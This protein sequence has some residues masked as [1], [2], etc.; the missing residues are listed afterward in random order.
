MWHSHS[1]FSLLV[2]CIP[3]YY[4]KLDEFIGYK[5]M[6]KSLGFADLVHEIFLRHNLSPKLMQKLDAAIDWL[7]VEQILMAHYTVGISG[8]EADAYHPPLLFFKC[9][10]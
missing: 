1:L 5:R 9:T 8:E 7:R 6:D 3:I 2:I 10:P 4:D